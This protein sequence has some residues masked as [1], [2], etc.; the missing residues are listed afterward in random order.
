MPCN[1]CKVLSV[2][3][4]LSVSFPVGMGSFSFFGGRKNCAIIQREQIR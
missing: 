2:R 3:I 1:S 4:G